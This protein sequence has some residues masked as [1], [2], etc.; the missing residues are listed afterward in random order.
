MVI[1]QG[2]LGPRSGKIM[3]LIRKKC[4]PPV[5]TEV[6]TDSLLCVTTVCHTVQNHISPLHRKVLI[7]FTPA[8]QADLR[9]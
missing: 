7:T 2:A 8:D 9:G 1:Q 6:V 4:H 3:S 5:T